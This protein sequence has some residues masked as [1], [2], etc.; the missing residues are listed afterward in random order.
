MKKLF[1][2][3]LAGL[4][5][6]LSLPFVPQAEG[7]A[8]NQCGENLFWSFDETSATLTVYGEGEME[9]YSISRHPTWWDIKD[10]VEHIV[11]EEGVTSIGNWAFYLLYAETLTLPSTLLRIGSNAFRVLCVTELVIPKNVVTIGN[12]AFEDSPYLR[13]V[14]IE[15]GNLSSIGD[16]AF[17]YCTELESLVLPENPVAIGKYAFDSTAI[18][19]LTIPRGFTEIGEYSFTYMN[20]LESVHIAGT[21]KKIGKHAFSGL[22]KLKELVFEEGLEEIGDSA[23]A[24]DSGLKNIVL[25]EG[26]EKIGDE[27]FI[28]CGLESVVLPDSLK[29]IGKGAFEN[30]RLKN[31]VFGNKIE[32]IGVYAFYKNQIKSVF[33]P[34]SVRVRPLYYYEFDKSVIIYGVPGSALEEVENFYPLPNLT[35]DTVTLDKVA[36]VPMPGME[37]S[38]DGEN[39]QDEP[40]FTGLSPNTEYTFYH[41]YA[42]NGEQ[43]ASPYGT[44]LKLKTNDGEFS[45]ESFWDYAAGAASL[46]VSGDVYLHDYGTGWSEQSW[47]LY[48]TKIKTLTLQ[49]ADKI[50]ARAFAKLTRLESVSLPDGLRIIGAHAFENAVSLQNIALPPTVT[51]IGDNAFY[52]AGLKDEL[53]LSGVSVIGDNA[54]ADCGGIT[55]VRF[56]ENPLYIG[57]G[58]FSGEKTVTFVF[59]NE[60]E[61]IAP[62]FWENCEN[63]TVYCK[64]NSSVEEYAANNGAAYRIFGDLNDDKILNAQ[65]LLQLKKLLINSETDNLSSDANADAKTDILDL[66]HLKKLL[67]DE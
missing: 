58:A 54:F 35:V 47:Y 15:N 4:F 31:V 43:E 23:F 66:I 64:K 60:A 50:G 16:F 32:F 51:E 40:V 37:Y 67:T 46:T 24:G 20:N 27:A 65:D 33:L 9:D 48:K 59:P 44:R 57:F 13:S 39:W 6:A 36:F 29:T 26:L 56:S 25:K 10:D 45:D 49:N 30:N 3:L 63:S 28:S 55:R 41:R 2:I 19:D 8:E 52:R 34:E 22:S 7:F 14:I 12:N 53:D 5:I 61:F 62:D 11:I 21:V 17:N 1:S 18:K 42:A 38:I